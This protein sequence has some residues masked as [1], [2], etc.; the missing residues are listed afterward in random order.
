MRMVR[1]IART[2]VLE[3]ARH[4]TFKASFHG[5]QIYAR[6]QRVPLGY[7]VSISVVFGVPCCVLDMTLLFATLDDCLAV[8]AQ[9]QDET[10]AVQVQERIACAQVM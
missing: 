6:R 5:F 10:I 8:P 9:I 3:A 4:G 2:A 7:C 1:A